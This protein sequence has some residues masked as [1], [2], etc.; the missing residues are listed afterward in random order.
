MCTHVSVCL[1]VSVLLVYVH[2]AV[3][4]CVSVHADVYACAH[5]TSLQDSRP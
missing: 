5:Y 4:E 1:R 3:C 2:V